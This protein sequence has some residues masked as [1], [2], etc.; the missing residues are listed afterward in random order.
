MNPFQEGIRSGESLYEAL[1]QN[2]RADEELRLKQKMMQMKG[3]TGAPAGLRLKP[4][5]VWDETTQT[6]RAVPGGDLYKS[7]KNKFA[8]DLANMKSIEDR[9]TDT[10]TKIEGLLSDPGF[11]RQFGGYNA[12]LTRHFPGSAQDAGVKLESLKSGLMA[13]G[14]QMM[15][16]GG[17][18]GQI[19]ERE[20][21]ILE[22]MIGRIS[23]MMSEEQAAQTLKDIQARMEGIKTRAKEAYQSE[24]AGSQFEN[25]AGSNPLLQML[26][27]P[28]APV[29]G[30]VTDTLSR[31]R[32]R[33]MQSGPNRR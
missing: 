24:W 6:V 7:Q 28:Q 2:R 8:G 30:G 4:G 1:Q 18:V 33:R 13:A 21:P 17:A 3:G 16:S 12:L 22:G 23:P 32:Q 15:A 20:W 11:S 19:T 31:I 10:Q 14:K 27:P 5:E 25:E 29:Q 9:S 26:Q